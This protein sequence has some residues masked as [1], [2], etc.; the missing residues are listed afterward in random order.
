MKHTFAC[1]ILKTAEVYVFDCIMPNILVYAFIFQLFRMIGIYSSLL[2]YLAN[3]FTITTFANP[4]LK[5]TS[6]RVS[7]T[8]ELEII[9]I[10]HC[11]VRILAEMCFCI[12]ILSLHC[13]R[14][15]FTQMENNCPDE[16]T[17]ILKCDCL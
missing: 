14:S 17:I 13:G 6:P 5:S 10:Y 9:L 8:L 2:L 3:V 4:A 1:S 12:R 16:D 15:Q 7:E 11:C